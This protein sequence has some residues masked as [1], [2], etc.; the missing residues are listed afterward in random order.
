M[1]KNQKINLISFALLILFFAHNITL[2]CQTTEAQNKEKISNSDSAKTQLL[3]TSPKTDLSKLPKTLNST[4]QTLVQP[5]VETFKRQDLS[6]IS[7]S[8]PGLTYAGGSSRPRFFQL[9]GLGERELFEG[10]P[11]S[12]VKVMYDELDFSGISSVV[13]LSD[14]EEVT[15][16]YGPQSFAVGPSAYAGAI[17]I[18]S[19]EPTEY[20]TG[21][22]EF[23]VS[24]N[25]GY[26]VTSAVGGKGF[27]DNNSKFRIS[28]NKNYVNG[29][30][31]N[32]F[33]NRDDTNERDGT[34]FRAKYNF[35]IDDNNKVEMMYLLGILDDGYDAFTIDNNFTTESD[36]VGKDT[37]T[38]NAIKLKL[39][40]ELSDESKL[41]NIFGII[42]S[43]QKQSYDADWGN[44]KFWEP[45]NPYDYEQRFKRTPRQ[46]SHELRYAVSKNK[47]ESRI[48]TD[49]EFGSYIA[50]KD[51]EAV[52]RDYASGEVI[53]QLEN[54]FSTLNIA[55]FLRYQ[56]ELSTDWV[57][58]LGA[59]VEER[60]LKYE[61][62][63]N[64]NRSNSET[65]LGTNLSVRNYK[66]SD[67]DN[68]YYST[69][70]L[71][72][73]PGGVNPGIS[74]EEN[75]RLYDSERLWNFEIGSKD[76]FLSEKIATSL[77]LFYG[78]RKS[79]Q[80]RTSSQLDP[81][82]PATFAYFTE[83]AAEG[84]M[85]GIDSEV[86]FRATDRLKFRFNGSLLKTN[87][88]DYSTPSGSINGRDQSY[89]PNWSYSVSS[90]YSLT[91][92]FYL[93]SRLSGKGAFYFDEPN[94]QKSD[95]YHLMDLH[96]GYQRGG[97][98]YE[99][100]G[101]NVFDREYAIRGFYFGNEPPNF[102]NKKYIQL[103]DPAWFGGT[104]RYDW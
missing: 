23:G 98:T 85:Y 4:T 3:V 41:V 1:K 101:R 81:L 55:P 62:S 18:K 75:R 24:S 25:D 102:E 50:Y 38:T 29:F 84:N 90:D 47:G 96:F 49:Y 33:L 51:D 83:N 94:I 88:Y 95:P 92:N 64:F 104:V 9:R 52:S 16:F 45:Y 48:T 79:Q 73:K 76:K 42:D 46:F 54:E 13:S 2:F 87:I 44:D 70:S 36:K 63:R 56:Y 30:R 78:I 43:K 93:G 61:D 69:I 15:T 34:N 32:Q 65:L 72:E 89:S 86:K 19:K 37:Q 17:S 35:N 60:T 11:D 66:D 14:I 53:N 40:S 67:N 58:D 28:I 77:S 5:E 12:S 10:V 27:G 59:R 7:N 82:N 103:G 20:F 21:N 74:V 100:W 31:R 97:W 91:D 6:E 8:I 99:I 80:V 68:F 71:G 57:L 39:T 22:T 26:N